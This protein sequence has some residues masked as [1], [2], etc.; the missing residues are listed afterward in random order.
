MSQT[1]SEIAVPSSQ[2]LQMLCSKAQDISA[3][4]K[5]DELEPQGSTR[6]NIVA[7]MLEAMCSSE[8]AGLQSPLG[9]EGDQCKLTKEQTPC[10]ARH[11]CRGDA[12]GRSIPCK[13]ATIG[14]SRKSP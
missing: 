6:G 9:T 1:E 8:P 13:N 12:I 7:G 10:E 3:A 4:A 5:A 14:R 11:R 2:V